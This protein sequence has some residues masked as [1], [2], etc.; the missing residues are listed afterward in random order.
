M[1]S[2]SLKN[3]LFAL[4]NV[5]CYFTT[6]YSGSSIKVWPFREWTFVHTP[7]LE[8]TSKNT[9]ATAQAK[10]YLDFL[11]NHCKSNQ[12]FF[13]FSPANSVPDNHHL[14]MYYILRCRGSLMF[15]LQLDYLLTKERNHILFLFV[16]STQPLNSW[17]NKRTFNIGIQ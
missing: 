15:S 1:P 10:Y 17:L 16:S 5:H 9:L 7:S 12:L 4:K 8:L 6:N 13:F 14:I 11:P 3:Q 2:R